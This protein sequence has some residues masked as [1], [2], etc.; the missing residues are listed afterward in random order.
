MIILCGIMRSF[1]E[2]KSICLNSEWGEFEGLGG[3]KFEYFSS[4]V[5]CSFSG[6]D[7]EDSRG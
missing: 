2:I 5:S 6:V 7:G 1:T 3:G 4:L